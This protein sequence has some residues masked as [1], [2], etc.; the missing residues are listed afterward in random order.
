MLFIFAR[1]SRNEKHLIH[2]SFK[3]TKVQWTVIL[4]RRQAETIIHQ[5][6]LSRLVSIVHGPQLRNGHV[7]LINHNQKI[8]REIIDKCVWRLPWFKSRQ[9]SG[10]V[11]N[12]GTKSGLS[13]HFYIEIGTFS[14][15]LSLQQFIFTF[16]IAH[17]FFQF[18][19]D[20]M[21]GTI[22]AVL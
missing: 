18:I 4:G 12:S 1:C 2:F 21:N 5:R 9:M 8:I 7:R 10:I 13:H 6:R 3:L 22:H 16:K 19:F 15:T 11:L 14:N 17:P 20:L